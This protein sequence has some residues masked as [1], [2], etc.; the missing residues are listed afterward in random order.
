MKFFKKEKTDTQSQGNGNQKF[1]FKMH[2]NKLGG[3]LFGRMQNL[4]RAIVLPIAV[5]PIAG[6]LLGIGGGISAAL[7]INKVD[8]QWLIDI[9]NI[10]KAAGQVVFSNLGVIFAVSIAFGFAKASKGVAALSG[11]IAFAVMTGVIAALFLPMSKDVML[12]DQN[13]IAYTVKQTFAGFD[14]WNLTGGNSFDSDSVKN[15][16]LFGN[17][18]GIPN[19]FDTSVLGGILVGWLVATVHN[20]SYNIRMPRLFAFFAGERFVPILAVFLGLGLGIVFFFL[21]PALLVAFKAIGTG[22]G[23]AMQ[24]N[25]HTQPGQLT[26]GDFKP[27]VG[28]AFIAMFFGITERLLIPTGLH[29]VQYTPFWYTP[30]G[31]Q[32]TDQNGNVING[33]YNIFFA[34]FGADAKGHFNQFPGTMFMSGRFAFMQYGYPFAA[35]A[36]WMLAKPQNKQVVA[37]ILG[38]AALTSFLTGI[39]EP[40]LFSFLFVAPL[41]F[42]WHSLMAGI[43]FMMAYC[44]NVVVGQGFAA[45]FIDFTV[46][47]I[48]PEALGKSTGFYWIFVTGLIMA[49]AYFFGFYYII[50]WRNYKTLGREDGEL[51]SNIAFASVEATLDKSSKK[52]VTKGVNLLKGLG[53]V[54]NIS[55]V[56]VDG[57]FLIATLNDVNLMSEALI[58]L[59][60]TKTVKKE[61]NKVRITYLEG[62]DAMDKELQSA[63]KNSGS[64]EATKQKDNSQER[65]ENIFKGLGGR[66]NVSVLDNC[67]TRLRVTVIDP[68]KVDEGILKSTGAVAV[69]KKGNGVQVIYGLEVANIKNDLV[70]IWKG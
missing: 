11:F 67:A 62:A 54:A 43:S 68:S 27:T 30:I 29:H 40:M 57:Q 19:T 3:H 35:L 14:P 37:G 31:G 33:A 22:M 47:G 5:L 16:G 61:D 24:T 69:V 48:L 23:S 55:D 41:C 21:W 36:M 63:I 39:T 7:T 59:T 52:G 46:F 6:L 4:A 28:G 12:F 42:V 18:L 70:A 60:G 45:G 1:S 56:E 34:Q 10:M 66:E 51:A 25:A 17:I 38:S 58:R 32:W 20:R 9:F 8:A 49:P 2:A 26:G 15:S 64:S 13:N 50:K 53:G 65:L 44:L